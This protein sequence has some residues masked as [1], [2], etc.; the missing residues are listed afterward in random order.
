VPCPP[1]R[2]DHVD[3]NKDRTSGGRAGLRVSETD[4]SGYAVLD[5]LGRKVGSVKKLYVNAQGDPEYVETK[6]GL[7]G[8]R[9]VLLHSPETLRNP[10]KRDY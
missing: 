7:L 6:S 3:P 2:R 9:V 5:P 10:T 4:T 8:L 1:A